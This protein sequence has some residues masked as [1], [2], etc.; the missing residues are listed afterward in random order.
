M[1]K[2]K[3][4]RFLRIPVTLLVFAIMLI[5]C[6][7]ESTD[8]GFVSKVKNGLGI[9]YTLTTNKIVTDMYQWLEGTDYVLVIEYLGKQT[10]RGIINKSGITDGNLILKLQPSIDNSSEFSVTLSYDDKWN[11]SSIDGEIAVEEGNTV[12]SPGSTSVIT[13]KNILGPYT[14]QTK[15]LT[16]ERK[17]PSLLTQ[18]ILLIVGIFLGIIVLVFLIGLILPR[19]K[20]TYSYTSDGKGHGTVTYLGE[21]SSSSGSTY[22]GSSSN[23]SSNSSNNFNDDDRRREEE[24]QRKVAEARREAER[25]GDAQRKFVGY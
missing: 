4:N 19:G 23:S 6:E 17:G 25:N 8:T 15:T 9:T 3:R 16:A 2:R 21:G 5:G 1:K 7:K 18:F 20:G 11:I 13:A 24:H 10:S 12:M 22:R 14:G